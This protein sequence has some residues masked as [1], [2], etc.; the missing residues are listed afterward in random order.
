MTNTEVRTQLRE[1]LQAFADQNCQYDAYENQAC[2]DLLKQLQ[3]VNPDYELFNE[4]HPNHG[5]A[6]KYSGMMTCRC[7]NPDCG[8]EAPAVYN[9]GVWLKPTEWKER[10]NMR[11]YLGEPVVI[12]VCSPECIEGAEK[13]IRLF[14]LAKEVMRNKIT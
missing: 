5:K 9:G 13:Q 4:T 7:D 8:K 11:E 1:L 10:P 6:T 2:L 3:P 12:Q 14:R